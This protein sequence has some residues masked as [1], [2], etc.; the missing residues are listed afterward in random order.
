[1]TAWDRRFLSLA[2]HVASWSKD[3]STQVGA[4]IVRPD[5]TIASLGFNGLPR[6]VPDLPETL[7]DRETKYAIV[8]H[9]EIN[10]VLHARE[11]LAGYTLYVWPFHPCSNCASAIV[12]AGIGRVVTVPS[13]VGRWRESFDRA[14]YVFG[15]AGVKVDVLLEGERYRK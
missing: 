2:E 12:Q 5:K 7:A 8:V 3:P 1:M 6:G 4:V 10:A 11:S 15:S 13:D 14:A 9:A